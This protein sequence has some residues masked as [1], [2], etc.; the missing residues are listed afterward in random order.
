MLDWSE[1]NTPRVL[2]IATFTWVDLSEISDYFKQTI[3]QETITSVDHLTRSSAKLS[4]QMTEVDMV[5]D[6][7]NPFP[8]SAGQLFFLDTNF[9]TLSEHNKIMTEEEFLAT[10]WEQH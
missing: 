4:L 2:M 8:S 6:L 1:A 3:R 10:H 5:N 7:F 9:D